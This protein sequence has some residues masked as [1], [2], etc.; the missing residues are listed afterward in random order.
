[1]S[2]YTAGEKNC[3]NAF[4]LF[5]VWLFSK[6]SSVSFWQLVKLSHVEIYTLIYKFNNN[7]YANP[8]SILF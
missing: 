1:M 4:S 7:F 5:P 2:S 6:Y 3:Y 8:L